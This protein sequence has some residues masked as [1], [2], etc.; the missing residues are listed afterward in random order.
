MNRPDIYLRGLGYSGTGAVIDWL[1]SSGQYKINPKIRLIEFHKNLLGFEIE[2]FLNNN[3]NKRDI[4]NLRFNIVLQ[5]IRLVF[6]NPIRTIVRKYINLIYPEYKLHKS[7]SE[8]LSIRS[9]VVDFLY[10]FKFQKSFDMS[11]FRSWFNL[12]NNIITKNSQSMIFDQG[13]PSSMEVYNLV[14]SNAVGFFVYRNP[15]NIIR[16]RMLVEKTTF[17]L[18]FE[19]YS[20]H[21]SE[22]DLRDFTYSLLKLLGTLEEYESVINNFESIL[23]IEFDEFISN[24]KIRVNLSKI[25]NI[26]PEYDFGPSMENNFKLKQLKTINLSDE[27]KSILNLIE[28]KYDILSKILQERLKKYI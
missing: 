14:E 17:K 1:L 12:K 20:K 4:F 18:F 16:Q 10:S 15:L 24:P 13:L 8:E 23:P 9:L 22:V 7:H 19:G 26:S 27:I 21:A 6:K 25:L 3:Y 5:I 28:Y 11:E 2:R